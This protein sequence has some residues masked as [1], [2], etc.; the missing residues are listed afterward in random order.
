[1]N[2]ILKSLL[3]VSVL[4]LL[5]H[6]G[7]AQQVAV[8]TI[9]I[10]ASPSP[11]TPV[12][13]VYPDLNNMTNT[14]PVNYVRTQVPDM[15]MND[16]S[17]NA[18]TYIR[19]STSY[20]DGLGRPLQEVIKKA[21]K[22]G[23]DLV[24]AHI[25]DST[26]EEAYRYLPYALP[27]EISTGKF[28]PWIKLRMHEFYDNQGPDEEPY[29]KTL[30]DKSPLK[31]VTKQLAPGKSWVGS[32]RGVQYEYRGNAVNE[33]RIW[34]IGT[35]ANA[36]PVSVATYPANEISVTKVTDEDFKF[37]MEY[38]D[39]SGKLILKKTWAYDDHQPDTVHN[40][41][42][43]TYYVYDDL[44][45]LRFV[46][47][48]EAIV[49]RIVTGSTWNLNQS[50][51]DGLCYQYFYD[52]KGRQVEKKIPGK[53]VEYFV[54]DKR[55][56][57]VM[58]QDG[59]LRNGWNWSFTVY[60]VLDRPVYHGIYSADAPE[61][62]ASLQS[63]MDNNAT[64]P[65]P[66][67]FYYLKNYEQ[68]HVYPSSIGNGKILGYNYYDDYDQLQ[69]FSFDGGFLNVTLP[70]NGTVVPSV[71]S[72]HTRG[73]LTG[74]KIRIMDPDAP[75][76]DNWLKTANYYDDKGR[77]IQTQ[78]ENIKG[79]VDI[80]SNIYYFQ[81]M[82]R[83]NILRHQNPAAEQIPGATDGALNEIVVV[84]TFE[85]NLKP[86]GGNDQVYKITQKI[87]NG[88]TYDFA[89]YSYD[90]LGKVTVKQFP[91]AN[92]LQ[93]YNIR[94]WLKDID[95][96]NTNN[97]TDSVHIFEEHL[98]YDKGFV[99]KM[100][101]GNIAGITWSKSGHTPGEAYGYSY[102]GLNRLTHAEYRRYNTALWAWMNNTYDYTT[103][104]ITYDMNGNLL[105]MDQRAPD[106]QPNGTV[107]NMDELTYNYAPLSNK[108]IKV[109][110]G[111]LP[112]A[113]T[114]LPDFKDNANL[115]VEYAYDDNG[116]IV[117]DSNKHISTITYNYLNK[118][119]KITV[120]GQGTITY[121]YDAWGNR[122][123]KKVVNANNSNE[124]IYDYI[125]NFVYKQN[126]LQ[127][128]LN[129][130]GRTRP[131]P[132]AHAQTSDFDTKFVYD[133]F[134]KDH[135]GNVRST[136]T[137]T[138]IN[139]IYLARHEIASANVEQLLFDNIPSVRDNK[140]GS[141]GVDDG[142]AARLDGGD[143]NRRVGTAIM[144]SVQPGDK[145]NLSVDAYYDG[146][147][148]QGNEIG[149]DEMVT[150]LMGALTG[151]STYAGVPMSELPD[152][153]RTITGALNNPLLASQINDLVNANNNP[154]A[155]K[156]HLNYLVFND[157][158][159][160]IADHSGSLQ[161]PV[162]PMGW[163]VVNPGSWNN[164]NNVNV[165]GG[166]VTIDEPG[167]IIVYI[168]NQTVGKEVWFDNLMVGLYKGEVVEENHYYPFGLTL[169]TTP[170][171]TGVTTQPYK[172]TTK[173]LE[174]NFGINAYDFGARMQDMQLGRWFGLDPLAE[175][176]YNINPYSFVANNPIKYKDASGA[177]VEGTDGK[178]VFFDNANGKITWSAN[179]SFDVQRVGNAMLRTKT[180]SE[181][182]KSMQDAEHPISMTLDYQ[183]IT[184]GVMAQTKQTWSK[185]GKKLSRMDINFFM[186]EITEVASKNIKGGDKQTKAMMENNF[187]QTDVLGANGAHE[188]VHAT[189]Q[190]NI[191]DVHERDN[192]PESKIETETPAKEKEQKYIDEVIKL[193]SNG[194]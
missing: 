14:L 146:A 135:L 117:A 81:G 115:P 92:V 174:S 45:R 183:S 184:P 161:V 166:F 44:Q 188:G 181:V 192:N 173:E 6:T 83:Q 100:Y 169:Q 46:I 25:Y 15:P 80:S 51:A 150:S 13:L 158:L 110:D 130:E 93:N 43:C 180:G 48:P 75:T 20:F 103:S 18:D 105:S 41:F 187:D 189:D 113:T 139:G 171:A 96:Q 138:P 70:N 143:A 24:Q 56:R 27:A 79:G 54:Y 40:G 142:M 137:A 76:A 172:L 152:H 32:D 30:L 38:K 178:P 47:P 167:Y 1:M 123:Q 133:Y 49:Q 35:A 72:T 23:F 19:Q 185:D 168:D 125:G 114:L 132:V 147:Y 4:S 136:V 108:L 122:L 160:L 62:R 57:M 34:T 182:F 112:G 111:V 61:P 90:H 94:G 159:E 194:Q 59:N 175:N 17:T 163:V 52:G 21:H 128:L 190:Q 116:N 140:P 121:V 120:D 11:V 22:D 37:S 144:L 102:D 16:L 85:R 107:I 2:F 88:I 154:D 91:A 29:G 127:Y 36:I 77:T 50:I 129:E 151:G 149:P 98:S 28:N 164:S 170:M 165:N 106:M 42:A 193:K 69:S 58:H 99:S 89:T 33:V 148:S 186:G 7:F 104:N 66:D 109:T 118:P 8:P 5:M 63:L 101:N 82:L 156:A 179:A 131:I 31:R 157:K 119:D 126:I 74:S 12:P 55:N 86:G 3:P 153:V 73:L 60:D 10:P 145:F 124:E 87:G 177:Y 134:I 141:T 65:S 155:P 71:L 9:N 53:D 95:V 78:S 64:Y 26:G 67:L 162:E 39:K 176:Y 84:K 97:V 191:K 68:C